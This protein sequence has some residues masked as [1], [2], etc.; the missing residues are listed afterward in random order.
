MSMDVQS[1]HSSGDSQAEQ[2]AMDDHQRFLK[3][4][5]KHQND[6]R[7]FVASMVR[8]WHRSEDIIQ[9]VSLVL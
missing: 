4:F 2:P 6:L 3:L 5:L 8:D 9:E 7:A 1:T